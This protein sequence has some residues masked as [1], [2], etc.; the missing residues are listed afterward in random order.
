LGV[1]AALVITDA[2]TRLAAS[3][4]ARLGAPGYE[5]VTVPHPIASASDSQLRESAHA[6]ARVAHAHLLQ[7]RG[8]LPDSKQ[9][10]QTA[11]QV[12]IA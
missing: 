5:A 6:A 12:H 10:S 11:A 9:T 8:E 1:P 4:A 3:F 7:P 2:F